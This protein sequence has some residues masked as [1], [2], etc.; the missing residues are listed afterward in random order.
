MSSMQNRRSKIREFSAALVFFFIM[1]LFMSFYSV[2]VNS[3][4]LLNRSLQISDSFN[5]VPVEN[6]FTFDKQGLSTIA[7]IEFEYCSNSP[8]QTDACTPPSGFDVSTF[9]IVSQSGMTGFSNS[10]ATTANRAI[11]TRAAVAEPATT[12]SYT[13]DGFNNPASPE[14][15]IYVRISIYDGIDATGTKVDQ[16]SVVFVL[17]SRY[18]VTAYVPPYLTFCVAVT[19]SLDCSTATGFLTD[20]GELSSVTTSASTT[21]FSA[22]TN[23]P[24]GYN[25]FV[26]GETLTSGNNVISSLA[27]L[28]GSAVSTS[29]FGIN[30]R[31]NNTPSVGANMQA[32]IVAS[33]QP[34]ADYNIQNQYKYVSG[35]RVAFANASTGFNLYTVSYI[36][37]VAESQAPGQYATTLTY[38]SIASF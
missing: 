22:A 33:G 32:G 2:S 31:S 26:T 27:V 1:S 24:T 6:L 36:V 34:D 19:V 13:I 14:S 15:I 20:F 8:L 35:D 7:S 23:D 3:L 25:T 28:Q 16:G 21:Q 37:N 30:L 38:T 18:D 10:V 12:A 11:I 9:S 17:D 4:D 29:Q 5:G